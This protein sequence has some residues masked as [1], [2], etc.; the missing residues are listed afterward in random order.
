MRATTT[1]ALAL[2]VFACGKKDDTPAK[3]GGK[4]AGGG[5]LEYPVEVAPLAVRQMQ[6]AVTAP[7]SID[8]FQQ[9]Q[10]T[11]RVT[12]AVDKVAFVEG[13]TVKAGDAM[14]SIEAE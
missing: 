6:Y 13:Q 12:G 5:K 7:G 8:A 4:R 1:L 10:I 3:G 9:V 11:A 2:L 14:V